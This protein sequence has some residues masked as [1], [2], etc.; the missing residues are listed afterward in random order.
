M[1]ILCT[2]YTVAA[3]VFTAMTVMSYDEGEEWYV[4]ALFAFVTGLLCLA[5]IGCRL[6]MR[7]VVL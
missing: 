5:A 2:L 7:G 4:T 6:I 3:M 1:I